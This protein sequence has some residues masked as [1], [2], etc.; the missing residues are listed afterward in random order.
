VIY[1]GGTWRIIESAVKDHLCVQCGTNILKYDMYAYFSDSRNFRKFKLHLGCA[2]QWKKDNR[3]KRKLKEPDHPLEP[4]KEGE[5]MGSLSCM[6]KTGDEK[7]TWDPRND[8]E[9][10]KAKDKF[11]ALL[12]E[13]YKAYRVN[14]A[15]AD[16]ERI[17]QFDP[18]AMEIVFHKIM[19]GG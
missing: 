10:R 7:L 17:D 2:E 1:N 19:A 5:D 6:D 12:K 14:H 3:T 13:G 4:N 18:L 11:Y 8:I 16:G 9:T 15:G